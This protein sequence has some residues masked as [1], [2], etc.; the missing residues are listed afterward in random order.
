MSKGDDRSKFYAHKMLIKTRHKL[1]GEVG[2]KTSLV[3]NIKK[4]EF[5]VHLSLS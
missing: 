1:R 3:D 2:F 5:V 4:G